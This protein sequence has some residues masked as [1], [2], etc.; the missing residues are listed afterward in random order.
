[1]SNEFL[2]RY[3]RQIMLPEIG[4]EKQLRLSNSKVLV[5]GAG[6]LGCPVLSYLAAAGIGM[7][8]IA[9]ADCVDLSN[10]QRQVLYTTNDIG[11][12]K[13][14]VAKELLMRQNPALQC[15]TYPFKIDALNADSIIG[16]YDLVVD[17]TDN[18]SS[19]Y[20]LNDATQRSNK[21]MVFASVF[22]F[23]GQLSVFNYKGG[24]TYRCLYPEPPA[25]DEVPNCSEIGVIGVLPGILGTLQA[26]EVIKII[27]QVGEV[28]A[29]V[30]LRIDALTLQIDRISFSANPTYVSANSHHT[31]SVNAT[32]LIPEISPSDLKRMVDNNEPLQL[33]DVREAFEFEQENIGGENVPLNTILQSL[34]HIQTNRPVVI[35]CLSGQRSKAAVATLVKSGY[36]NVYS[37]TG[38]IRAFR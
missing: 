2:A 12:L 7:I 9:D 25:D 11:R 34:Q 19:R 4:Y 3:S 6:G 20:L 27:T 31:E 37:L 29:G 17:C 23:E 18:F 16:G 36:K 24:P 15:V 22:K 32:K 33:I 10:L 26:N 21:P 14:E 38:G 35:V 8:G 13:V 28:L 30:L 1:M 5:V